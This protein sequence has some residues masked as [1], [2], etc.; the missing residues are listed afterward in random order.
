MR[1]TKEQV[2]INS[3]QMIM[4]F[5]SGLIV[6][7]FIFPAS[8]FAKDDP[9]LKTFEK[10]GCVGFEINDNGI[11]LDPE[12]IDHI[13]DFGKSY[14]GSSEFGLY[15][16]KMFVEDNSGTLNITSP[17]KGEGTTVSVTFEK[18]SFAEV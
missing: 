15:Y 12:E 3:K 8:L 13:F 2:L 1:V 4:K 6:C 16:C 9:V 17:Q 11:G 10:N 18:Q 7:L 5:I 14:K